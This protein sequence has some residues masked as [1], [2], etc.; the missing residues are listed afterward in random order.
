MLKIMS[1]NISYYGTRHG[2][3]AIRRELIREAIQ[4]AQPHIVALQAVRKDPNEDRGVDQA[5][6][7]ANLMPEYRYVA[8]QPAAAIPNGG[9]EGSAII[10]RVRFAET[11]YLPLRQIPNLDDKNFR[12]VQMTRFDFRSA[13]FHLFN[14]HFSWVDEQAIAN[15]KQTFPYINSFRGPALLVGDLNQPPES[16]ALERLA[17]SDWTDAWAM[18]CP[19]E[20]GFTFE[21]GNLTKRIDYAWANF[22]LKPD[23]REIQVVA[24]NRDSSGADVSDHLGLLI[25]LDFRP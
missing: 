13:M 11:S 23:L 9:A 2:P 25:T 1:L 6:Q 8:F 19:D 5:T 4:S 3:W 14:A 17:H 15:V 20:D 24:N 22:D 16:P 18:L 12:V 10:S 21:T 7:L